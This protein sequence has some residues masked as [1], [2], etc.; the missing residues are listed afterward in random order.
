MIIKYKNLFFDTLRLLGKLS[1][2]RLLNLVLIYL[3]FWLSRLT[4]RVMVL[5]KP[6]ALSA[7]VSSLCN[8]HCPQC[9]KGI[10]TTN[11]DDNNLSVDAFES[12]VV[13][14]RESV[15]YANLYFQGEPFLNPELPQ[16]VRV[17]SNLGIYTSISTNG[18]FLDEKTCGEAISAGLDRLIVSIDG[19]DQITYSHYRIGGSLPRVVEGVSTMVR[20]RNQGLSKNPFIVLQFLVNRNNEHQIPDLRNFAR[21]LGVD[22]VQLKSMQVYENTNASDFLPSNRRYNRYH[23]LKSSKNSSVHTT[24]VPCFRLYSHVVFTSDGIAVP[25]CYDKIPQ[26]PLENKKGENHWFSPKLNSF[27]RKVMH[28]RKEVGICCNCA[29]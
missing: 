23:A 12:M 16:I 19:L 2:A 10:K 28:N 22:M 5:G 20:V 29:G 13:R 14:Y 15:F 24:G 17:A 9:P 18:H 27:R 11:R 8:L 7:E 25:C 21:N 1:P 3:G 6:F 4:R 26:Y